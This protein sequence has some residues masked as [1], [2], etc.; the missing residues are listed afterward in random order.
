VEKFR[1]TLLVTPRPLSVNRHTVILHAWSA[2]NTH[3]PAGQFPDLEDRSGRA[4]RRRGDHPRTRWDD[5]CRSRLPPCR[6]PQRVPRWPEVK[7]RSRGRYARRHSSALV[8]RS[9][10]IQS[11]VVVAF[12]VVAVRRSGLH[13][14]RATHST[15]TQSAAH[16]MAHYQS[17]RYKPV[18]CLN[19][20][21]DRAMMVFGTEAMPSTHLTL[22]CKGRTPLF[23]LVVDLL[24]N[25][26]YD[27]I[28]N[29][30]TRNLQQI[31]SCTTSPQESTTIRKST[32]NPKHLDISTCC[33]TNRRLQQV[34]A[35]Q[36]EWGLFWLS[37]YLRHEAPLVRWR[38]TTLYCGDSDVISSYR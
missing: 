35:R 36:I 16:A 4:G 19:G 1:Y 3:Q 37:R 15:H 23:R 38:H 22:C 5:P 24:Q 7:R 20:W 27:R 32:T 10:L 26:L 17:V 9:R 6:A 11:S 18:S 2:V 33:A 29:K 21:M 25:K 28:R 34:P 30:S 12:V 8:D 31:E 13:F 14:Y